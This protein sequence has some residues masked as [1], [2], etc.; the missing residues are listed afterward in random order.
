MN[1]WHLTP[2]TPRFPFHVS[3][4]ENVNLQFGTWPIEEGQETWIEFRV[5]HPDGTEETGRVDGV[6]NVNRDGNSYWYLNFGPFGDGDR[7]EYRVMGCSRAGQVEVGM[8]AMMG[9]EATLTLLARL[10]RA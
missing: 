7:V 8:T 4:G 2:D 9:P 10:R 1:L 5:M 3:A 6:W